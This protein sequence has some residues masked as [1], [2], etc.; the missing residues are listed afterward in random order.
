MT[1]LNKQTEYFHVPV[2]NCDKDTCGLFHHILSQNASK[3]IK[4]VT[5][6]FFLIIYFT[7]IDRATKKR[8]KYGTDFRIT[9]IC[10]VDDTSGV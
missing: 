4:N 7:L 6:L 3:W 9:S 2:M 8:I 5:Q 1:P 10:V